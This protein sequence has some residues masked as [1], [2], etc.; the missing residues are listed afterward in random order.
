MKMYKSKAVTDKASGAW[1]KPSPF[2]LQAALKQMICPTTSDKRSSQ[3]SSSSSSTSV[4]PFEVQADKETLDKAPSTAS[5]QGSTDTTVALPVEMAESSEG[6]DTSQHASASQRTN[7][8]QEEDE[9]CVV[10]L[11][12]GSGSVG[13]EDFAC[14]TS[15]LNTA[16]D[17]VAT[18]PNSK[19]CVVQFSNDSRVEVPLGP[20]DK[21]AFEAAIKSMVR[22]N[23]GTNIAA[24]V[25]KAGSLLK[26]LP[27]CSHHTR[28]V[29]ALLTDGRIDSYQAREA[30]AMVARLADEQANVGL[31]AFGVGRGVDAVELMRIIEG[32]GKGAKGLGKERYVELC[33]RDD[34]PW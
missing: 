3:N 21:P 34:A 22:M 33:V 31:W 5:S 19:L 32:M 16:A 14:M 30:G 18:V 10:F 9:L 20:L 6:D 25:A 17:T 7:E 29:L 8:S 1:R 24:A 28:R 26:S 11:I 2:E 4:K 27:S 23:G 15:F 13:E 12:D